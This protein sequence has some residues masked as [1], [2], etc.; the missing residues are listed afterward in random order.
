MTTT[1]ILKNRLLQFLISYL[2]KFELAGKESRMRSRF[3]TITTERIIELEK[4]RIRML[5]EHSTKD[6]KGQSIKIKSQRKN[7][8]NNVEEYTEYDL[9]NDSMMLFRQEYS[10]Y[11]NEDYIIDIT[12]SNKK[13][14][15]KIKEILLNS[16]LPVKGLE[17]ILYD[18]ICKSFEKIEDDKK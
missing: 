12:E 6:K 3:I 11:L 5:E 16:T 15:N 4:E 18:E 13:E 2:N 17:A 8:F 10:E 1:L 7:E 14:I 9:S